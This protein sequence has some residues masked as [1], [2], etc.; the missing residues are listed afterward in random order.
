MKADLFSFAALQ[1]AILGI[2][3]GLAE[4]LPISSSAHL[5]LVRYA[6]GW[7]DFLGGPAVEKAFDVMLH[8]GTLLALVWYFFPD[9]KSFLAAFFNNTRTPEN[10][11]KRK[12]VALLIISTIPGGLFGVLFEK[13]AEEKFS[14]PIPIAIFMASLGLVLLLAELFSSHARTLEKISWLDAIIIGIG[15]AFALLPGVSRSGITMTAG[16]FL[17]FKREDCARYSFL[18]SIP[19][20]A[21]AVLWEGHKLIKMHLLGADLVP[22][23]TGLFTSAVVGYLCIR[24]FLRYLSRGSFYPFV[25]YR[26]LLGAATFFLVSR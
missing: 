17:G 11:E 22:I 21:G 1:A 6:L 15:Q 25:I 2:V 4:F 20:I 3:Q 26:L 23:S 24:Y 10:R 19:L 8:A 16:L 5:V 7:S 13:A 14:Q 18:I 12:L 9:L